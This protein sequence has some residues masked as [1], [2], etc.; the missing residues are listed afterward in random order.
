MSHNIIQYNQR[1]YI[2]QDHFKDYHKY[3][4]QCNKNIF[5]KCQEHKDHQLISLEDIVINK[6]EKKK[7]LD[8]MKVLI[9]SIIQTIKEVIDRLNG[10]SKTINKYYEINIKYYL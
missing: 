6:E 3:C 9:D 8:N 5:F 2:C 7:I 1:N 10:F 4:K